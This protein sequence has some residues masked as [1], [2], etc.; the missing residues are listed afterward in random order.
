MQSPHR[1]LE[2]NF[3]AFCNSEHEYVRQRKLKPAQPR[4]HQL[5]NLQGFEIVRNASYISVRRAKSTAEETKWLLDAKR[6]MQGHLK[7]TLERFGPPPFVMPA[8]EVTPPRP[9]LVLPKYQRFSCDHMLPLEMNP[10]GSE[11]GLRCGN[12]TSPS[13][14]M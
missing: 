12:F 10:A 14:I 7:S 8:V 6:E 4:Q 5:S 1:P 3:Q 13:T 9:P 2:V 11:T